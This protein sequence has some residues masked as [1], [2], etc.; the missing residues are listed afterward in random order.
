MAT[1]RVFANGQ[2]IEVQADRVEV[3]A[4]RNMITFFMTDGEPVGQ[5][6]GASSFYKVQS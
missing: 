6:F 2:D 1:Y 4:E 3:F 5:F